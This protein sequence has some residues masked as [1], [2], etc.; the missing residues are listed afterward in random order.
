MACAALA[1]TA[2]LAPSLAGRT[3]KSAATISPRVESILA[4]I[5]RAEGEIRTLRAEVTETRR[6]RLLAKPEVLRGILF[7]ARPEQLRWDYTSPDK[8]TY[9]LSEGKMT[10]WIPDQNRVEMVD[11]SSRQRKIRRLVAI[12]QDSES[13][14]REFDMTAQEVSSVSGTSELVLVPKS[15]RLRHRLAEIRLWIDDEI[16]LPRQ[17]R[18]LTG[19]GDE[20]LLILSEID[21]NGELAADTFNLRVPEGAKVVRE[22]TSFGLP[23]IGD[24]G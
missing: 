21:I 18:Y 17:L 15:R 9:I 2:A 23:G 11:L 20:V 14:R 24:G 5:D 8:R 16:G 10:G 3:P 4:R 7:F 19:G 1:V 13:L 12:G 22:L 6:L